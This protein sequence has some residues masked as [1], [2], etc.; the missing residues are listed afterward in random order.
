MLDFVLQKMLNRKWI[1]ICL[2]IGNILMIS[3][4]SANPMYTDAI[5]IKSLNREISDYIEEKNTYPGIVTV[6]ASLEVKNNSSNID[7]FLTGLENFK[8]MKKAFKVGNLGEIYHY[9]ISKTSGITKNIYGDTPKEVELAV[10][11]MS[12]LREHSGIVSGEMYSDEIGS[13]G[14]I[15]AVI[16]QKALVAHRLIIG[17]VLT[18]DEIV[19]QSGDPLKVKITG[20]FENNDEEDLY[21]V[22]SPNELISEL[23]ISEKIFTEEFIDFDEPKYS[24]RAA[25]YL[26][27][28]CSKMRENLIPGLLEKTQWYENYFSTENDLVFRANYVE[29][30]EEHTDM[31]HRVKSTLRILQIPV[32]ILL[33]AFIFMV[34]SQ[35]LEIEKNDIAILKSRGAGKKQILYAYFLQSI[36]LA[37]AGIVIGLPVAAFLCQMFGSANAFLS[38]VSRGALSLRLTLG[39]VGYCLVSAAVCVVAMII[40]VFAYANTSIVEHKQKKNSVKAKPIW[41]KYFFDIIITAVSIYGLINFSR[42]KDA[43]AEAVA[44]GGSLDPLLYLC[45]SLFIIGTG[46]LIL[47]LLPVLLKLLFKIFKNRLSP[48][49][50][51]ASLRMLRS[52]NRQNFI[53]IFLILTLALG[54]FNAKAA[55]TINY[56]EEKNISYSIGADIVLKE[57]WPQAADEAAV[58]VD[59]EEA[60]D[61][62][63][64][65][66]E[67]QEISAMDYIEPDFDKYM[68]IEG[69]RNAT[70]VYTTDNAKVGIT[71]DLSDVTMENIHTYDEEVIEAFYES[72]GKLDEYFTNQNIRLMGIHTKD[73]GNTAWF[74]NSLLP[75]HWYHYLN[76][77]SQNSS[78]ILVSENFHEVLG[79][80]L[81]DTLI[82]RTAT[83]A[84]IKGIIFGFV[85]YWPT[86]NPETAN[87]DDS[88]NTIVSPNFMIV[89]N[90]SKL[91]AE[92]G[93]L[94]YEVWLDVEGSTQPVYDFI[95]EKE[96][97]LDSFNDIYAEKIDMK[98][99]PLIQGTNGILTMG[100]I[101]VLILCAVG[102]LIYWIISVQSRSLQFGIFRAMGMT[103]KEI[104]IMLLS[105][106]ALITIPTVFVGVIV[107][108]VSSELFIPLIQI[109]YTS[110]ELSLPLTMA[111]AFWDIVKMFIAV[112]IAVGV[113]VWVVSKL[114]DMV[115]ISQA[116]KLGED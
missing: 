102:L 73:F 97:K 75:Q 46:L 61:E 22:N 51:A 112:I 96:I 91:Q 116:L 95:G 16:S 101:V 29:L 105:E 77:I 2:L 19:L 52:F 13:D 24:L 111:G 103:S 1:V 104:I 110:T 79:Y 60:S 7:S 84:E 21:W 85:E 76:A 41:K 114:V 59:T 39:V 44:E 89:A 20:V 27:L 93:V 81:G 40:P 86:Y 82:Y 109:A 17:E 14:T 72:G 83:G 107:G 98:N 38:F 34:S 113:C 48:A 26:L 30:L 53:M 11:Y 43:L 49:V 6:D 90:L 68:T 108:L 94:P 69:V 87:V 5:Q 31:M 47:R 92:D 37:G 4:A 67:T 70:K 23:F 74:E 62:N 55:H 35:I 18:F 50:Y 8:D 32:L 25:Y 100:F 115:K 56:N 78:A 88:G 28:D 15:E 33:L 58:S 64:E 65:N 12:D 57:T 10:G 3:V 42:Q 106:Q 66:V 63:N 54:I 9:Y 36:I 99:D 45:S 71:V 80:Q